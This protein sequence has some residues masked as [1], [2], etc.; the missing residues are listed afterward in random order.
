LA[1]DPLYATNAGR[2]ENR[3]TLIPQLAAAM[4][5]QTTAHWDAAL[6]AANVPAGPINDIG[7]ALADP[8]SV[9][10]GLATMAGNRPAIASPLRLSDSMPDAGSEPPL[11]GQNTAE[12]L[13][14]LMG[15]SAADIA[16]LKQRSVV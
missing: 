13:Q 9:A 15:H 7:Q 5:T 10:R 1:V 14:D 3:A 12:V 2:V 16:A 8:Q 6:S 4:K 11:L